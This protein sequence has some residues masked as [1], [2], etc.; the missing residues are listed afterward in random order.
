MTKWLLDNLDMNQYETKVVFAN[1]GREREETL[2]FIHNCDLHFGFGTIWVE[3]I[4]NPEHGRELP[5]VL[6]LTKPQVATGN[7]SRKV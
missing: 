2:E 1:T 4:T 3:C 5:P 6:L 7:R